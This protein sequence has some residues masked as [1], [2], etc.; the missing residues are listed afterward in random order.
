MVRVAIDQHLFKMLKYAASL[1]EQFVLP[2]VGLPIRRAYAAELLRFH[3][4]F[5]KITFIH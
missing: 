3:E 1:L 5:G 2:R 4:A